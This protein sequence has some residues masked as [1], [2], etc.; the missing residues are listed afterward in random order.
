MTIKLNCYGVLL[1]TVFTTLAGCQTTEI[2]SPKIIPQYENTMTMKAEDTDSDGD[3][4]LDQID[5]CPKTPENVAVNELGCP[6]LYD[7]ID[8]TAMELRVFFKKDSNELLPKYQLELDKVADQ[9]NKYDNTTMQ[10]EAH[11]SEDE[12]D[13]VSGSLSKDRALMVKNYLI[14]KHDVE[15]MRLSTFDC[16]VRAPIAPSDTEEGKFFNRRVYGLVKEPKV[17]TYQQPNDSESDVCV[18]F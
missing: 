8:K 10:I 11:I 2:A 18:E 7:L 1:L 4:V 6:I 3:G 16:S 13:Q 12:I 5:H 14:L 15:P 17:N 9:M